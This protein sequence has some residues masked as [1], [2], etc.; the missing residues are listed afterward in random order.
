ML[1]KRSAASTTHR[2]YD[3]M[4]AFTAARDADTPDEL[5]LCEHPPVYTQ[6]LAGRPSTCSTPGDIPVV[7]TDR[8]GQVTYHGPGPGGGLS[9]DRP[10]A[11]SAIYVK[12][13]VYRLEEA[14]DQDAGALRRDRPP[15]APARRASTCGWTIRSA[16]PRSTGPAEP[17]RPV[18]RARQDRRAGH[19]GQPPLHLPRR[20]AERGDGPGPFGASTL[21][22]MPGCERSI[23][24]QSASH[25][26]WDEAAHVLGAKLARLPGPDGAPRSTTSSATRSTPSL[27]PARQAEGRGQDCRASRSRWCRPRC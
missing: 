23:F 13:Y 12:E 4:R 15:G 16:M 14:R 6:G 1:V 5:W 25:A 22:A 21:A 3:A 9:A 7:Q 18:P 26:T 20:G 10:A 8:G 19:Q 17:R 2:R 24:L 27:R 11:R